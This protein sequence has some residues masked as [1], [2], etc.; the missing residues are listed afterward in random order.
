MHSRHVSRGGSLGFM[1]TVYQLRRHCKA[2][3]GLRYGGQECKK[4]CMCFAAG[5][6]RFEAES[7]R[8]SLVTV[9]EVCLCPEQCM[10]KC[11]G[12]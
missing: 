12:V 6:A 3:F 2:S 4:G 7:T 11:Q 10:D 9:L 8:S 1:N 5:A